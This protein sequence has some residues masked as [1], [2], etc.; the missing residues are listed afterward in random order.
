VQAVIRRLASPETLSANTLAIVFLI[1][2]A[3]SSS[4]VALTASKNT[5]LDLSVSAV[6][7]AVMFLLLL[8]CHTLFGQISSTTL[9]AGFVLG[10]VVVANALRAAAFAVITNPIG[11]TDSLTRPARVL[12][13]SLLTVGGML[14]VG[15]LIDRHRRF[16]STLADLAAKQQELSIERA[17]YNERLQR[18]NFELEANIRGV[19]DPTLSLAA[20]EFDDDSTER[21]SVTSA[22]LLQEI[23]RVRIRPAIVTLNTPTEPLSAVIE[24]PRNF[25]SL[26][27]IE[28]TSPPVARSTIDIFDSIR[29]ALSVVPLRII[30]IPLY[31]T[32][33]G[34]VQGLLATLFFGLAW[35][36]LSVIR[37]LWP[38]RFRILPVRPAIALMTACFLV[39]FGIPVLAAFLSPPQV[40]DIVDRSA[41]GYVAAA[42]LVFSV[43]IAWFV[44][45]VFILAR[46]RRLTQEHLNKVNDQIGLS[47]ARMR[48]EIWFTQQNLAWVLHGPVQSALI[49]ASI[50]LESGAVRD[51]ADRAAILSSLHRAYELLTTA[52]P[53]VPDFNDFATELTGLWQG[54]CTISFNDSD[55][56]MD[57]VAADPAA[58]YA[59]IEVVRE[60]VGNAIRHGDATSVDITISD[61]TDGLVGLVITDNG[62][63]LSKDATPGIGSDLFDSLAYSWSRDSSATI[64]TINAVLT[65]SPTV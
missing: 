65:W 3:G 58:T 38:K 22:Q 21:S 64:T 44:A 34:F 13:A 16:Q 50:R 62:R 51:A 24:T 35:P 47:I 56:V 20:L 57:R 12:G 4:I 1:Y 60:A 40:S 41:L 29:P 9:R 14:V 18:A 43:A 46:A 32:A 28:A 2:L 36:L 10:I 42:N 26:H 48:Q 49:S 5:V 23:L 31:I 30:G 15:E 19:L 7:S 25:D 39:A 45:T 55:Q 33:L 11:P 17:T 63:G 27:H 61:H 37:H 52:G 54:V 6:L 8:A 53:G 59:V